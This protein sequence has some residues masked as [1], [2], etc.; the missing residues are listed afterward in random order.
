MS[1]VTLEIAVFSVESALDAIQ[2]GAHRIELCE[3]PNEGGTTPS[4]GSLLAMSKQQTVPVF[5]SSD[6]EAVTFCIRISNIKS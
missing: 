6:Q 2:A 5:Q 1:K 4:Y 3:N